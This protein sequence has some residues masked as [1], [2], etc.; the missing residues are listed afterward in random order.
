MKLRITEL[1]FPNTLLAIWWGIAMIA[2]GAIFWI[3]PE[4]SPRLCLC[5]MSQLTER[6]LI[7]AIIASY[8][9]AIQIY[10]I[11]LAIFKRATSSPIIE[12]WHNIMAKAQ[13]LYLSLVPLL[14]LVPTIYEQSSVYGL[15]NNLIDMIVAP[16]TYSVYFFRPHTLVAYIGYFAFGTVIAYLHV[17][18]LAAWLSV[19]GLAF[20]LVNV[21]KILVI[22]LTITVLI[23]HTTSTFIEPAIHEGWARSCEGRG[24]G[25]IHFTES[26]QLFWNYRNINR[27]VESIEY[28]L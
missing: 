4:I 14:L 1:K 10:I 19:A 25:S 15:N 22:I 12:K 27:L 8:F 26:C 24:E 28:S 18:V 5:S 6:Y 23:E 21:I 11:R 16:G 17:R 2:A 9:I 13:L 7:F 20:R 3:R